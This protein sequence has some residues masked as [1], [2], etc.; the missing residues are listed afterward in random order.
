M[1]LF[2]AV[3]ATLRIASQHKSRSK[4]RGPGSRSAAAAE[5]ATSGVYSNPIHESPRQSALSAKGAPDGLESLPRP[6]GC[7]QAK[8]RQSGALSAPSPRGGHGP[9]ALDWRD[10]A[11][12]VSRV[13][14]QAGRAS[15]DHW[16]P[17][18][19]E[20]WLVA[21]YPDLVRFAARRGVQP[22]ESAVHQAWSRATE[23]YVPGQVPFRTYFWWVLHSE[24][25]DY[26]R[27][28]RRAC[29]SVP[30]AEDH[31]VSVPEEAG[32]GEVASRACLLR[33]ALRL[34]PRKDLRL[35]LA[36]YGQRT[37]L[38]LLA[39]RLGL[40]EGAL[41]MRLGRAWRQASAIFRAAGCHRTATVAALVESGQIQR[42][43]LALPRPACR[44]PRPSCRRGKHAAV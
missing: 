32:G 34:L 23:R 42:L 38:K 24:V 3:H 8:P 5:K 43:C 1:K 18:E 39:K 27:A 31:V 21:N 10:G 28:F 11:K 17:P 13:V 6:L 30:L 20:A 7:P 2:F 12:A 35:L 37:P 36:A 9:E 22:P 14:V 19:Y 40:T 15:Q 4:H 33:R 26:G 29:R 16:L 44:K 25:A 41:K